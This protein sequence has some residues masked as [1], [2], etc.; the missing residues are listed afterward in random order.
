MRRAL[1][2]EDAE[3]AI[4]ATRDSEGRTQPQS[5]FCLMKCKL[6]FSLQEFMA[7]GERKVS[8]WT[9]LHKTISV[10]FQ[11]NKATQAAFLNANTPEDLLRLERIA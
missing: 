1:I 11:I 3:I 5:V 10:P 7:R 8:A 6:L 9:V 2:A 4:A